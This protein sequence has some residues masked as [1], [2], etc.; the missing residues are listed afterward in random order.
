MR[1]QS[2]RRASSA[3]RCPETAVVL[4]RDAEPNPSAIESAI[5]GWIVPVL[6]KEFLA[7]HGCCFAES[8]VKTSESTSKPMGKEDVA[9]R[10]IN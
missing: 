3:R 10:H 9:D 6:V 2:S 7:E 8:E 1:P 5:R 4:A